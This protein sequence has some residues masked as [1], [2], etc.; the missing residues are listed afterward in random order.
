VLVSIIL[1]RQLLFS[2]ISTSIFNFQHNHNFCRF[3]IRVAVLKT[4]A[5]WW[6]TT[7]EP[8][9]ASS[10]SP[11]AD[12]RWPPPAP[13][14]GISGTPHRSG[15]QALSLLS[16]FDRENEPTSEC[17]FLINSPRTFF[18]L[19]KRAFPRQRAF[20]DSFFSRHS[21]MSTSPEDTSR[22]NHSEH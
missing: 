3:L 21:E 15:S 10:S 4:T 20:W 5:G 6:P 11:A 16:R 19:E 12:G 22:V 8:Y 13:S 17:P 2:Y 9:A 7:S 14:S 18:F 1:S